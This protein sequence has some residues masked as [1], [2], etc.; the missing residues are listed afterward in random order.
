[1][2][3]EPA[4]PPAAPS[5]TPP[6]SAAAPAAPQVVPAVAGGTLATATPAAPVTPVMPPAF[7]G[8][9][10][11]WGK[12]DD[13]GKTAAFTAANDKATLESTARVD[14]FAKAEGKDAKLA[15]YTALNP[16]EKT[17]AFKDMPAEVRKEL[18][19]EDPAIPQ[20][21]LAKFKLPEGQTMDPAAL[22]LF[23][24]ERLS[25]ETAQKLIDF[26]MARETAAANRSL[27]TFV[28]T[29]TK[30]V[31]EIKSDPEIGGD[32]LGQTQTHC[33]TLIDRLNI[34]GLREA[35]DLTGA[36]DNPAVVRAFARLGQMVAED[37]FRPGGAAPANTQG[38]TPN[39]YGPEGPKQSVS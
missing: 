32:K 22:E 36:G 19:V 12:L 26:A 1:M 25:Q 27:Q 17:K 9:A 33:A 28:D 3:D 6:S 4:P 34:P 31:S 37:K 11:A 23:K 35:L 5:A 16:D 38:Q 20:Y 29:R 2:A 7:E 30:W 18:G 21:D 14:A 8:G 15:A 13:A 10:D 24:G 39:Y